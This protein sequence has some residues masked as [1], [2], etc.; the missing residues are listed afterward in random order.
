MSKA[1]PMDRDPEQVLDEYL[2]MLA[3]AGSA[4][5]FARLAAR[6]TPRL[7]R[8]AGR[9]LASPDGADD[10]VQEAWL[11]I[12]RGL[13]R[14]DDPARFPAWALA[15]TSRRCIDVLRRRQRDRRLADGLGAEARND[16]APAAPPADQRL[17]LAAAIARLPADQRLMVSLFYGEDQT[18]E[19]IA[20]A[21]GLAPGTVKSRLH[22]AR[23]TLKAHLE[24][25]DR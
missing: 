18:V 20:D 25:E 3:R 17:D 24:G 12:A 10:A 11:G 5:A 15:I 23:Q 22:A 1:G 19:T 6:W 4:T 2:V 21:H 16:A 9:L 13:K 8:H 14:L 7:R